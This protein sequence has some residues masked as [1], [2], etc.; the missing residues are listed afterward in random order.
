MIKLKNA[1]EIEL[2][3]EAG[4]VTQ[5]AL[6]LAGT[7]VKPGVTTAS[8]DKAICDEIARYGAV[9]SFLGYN[10]FPAGS[11]ISIN[12]QVIH[13]IPSDRKL[14]DGDIVKI[15]V[16]V[17]LNGWQGD[18]ANT[19]PCGEVTAAAA[20]LIEVT[21]QSFFEGFEALK[22]ATRLGDVSHAIQQTVETNGFSVVRD[23]VGHGIGR[24]LH[25]DPSVPNFGTAGRGV[26]LCEG[27]VIA[28]EPMVNVG[29]WKIEILN[30][31]WTVVTHDRSLS[32]HYENT[33]AITVNGP[34]ILTKC[35]I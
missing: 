20:K 29:D 7:L 10:G 1:R 28:I 32:A 13:G 12:E 18:C 14:I 6:T 11:C 9:P 25:E 26:R 31:K 34:E 22:S 21:R 15:D 30:D 3:R 4:K 23:F 33:V 2:M 35:D 19:F 16:G 17:I 5:S 24:D 27:M 8:I